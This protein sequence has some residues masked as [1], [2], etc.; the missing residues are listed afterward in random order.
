[1][2]GNELIVNSTSYVDD[3]HNVSNVGQT[4]TA[5]GQLV[6][7]PTYYDPDSNV[8]VNVPILL[9]TKLPTNPLFIFGNYISTKQLTTLNVLSELIILTNP[10]TIF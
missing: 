3:E 1:M 5:H 4:P 9:P 8:A 6:L 10:P 7:K 2:Y